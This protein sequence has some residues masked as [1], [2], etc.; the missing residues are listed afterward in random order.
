MP[1][2]Y[3]I[4]QHGESAGRGQAGARQAAAARSTD[5]DALAASAEN[6]VRALA[7]Q[8]GITLRQPQAVAAGSS[9]NRDRVTIAGGVDPAL[10]ARA[11][12]CGCS[13]RR[14]R[15]ESR[16]LR[17]A[18][19]ARA[20]S[21]CS[22]RGR[23]RRRRRLEATRRR[24]AARAARAR[25]WRRTSASHDQNGSRV[26]LAAQR[27]HWVIVTFLY[28][29]C[30]DV[31]PVIA[32]NLNAALGAPPHAAAGLRV[33]SVS[34]DPARDTPAAAGATCATTA[35]ADVP[36]GA[37]QRGGAGSTVWQA[38]ESPCCPASRDRVATRRSSS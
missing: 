29:Y 25:R 17:S 3:G 2:G 10:R 37:R 15:R 28:T 21:S 9:R 22:R 31:C 34:V 1:N 20:A 27:G 35:A 12:R 6:A 16:S 7:Q 5:G 36:L 33:L 4:F 18:R 38:Y 13:L 11:R 26:T 14:R 32:G 19:L 24:T 8:R 30:P 23:L